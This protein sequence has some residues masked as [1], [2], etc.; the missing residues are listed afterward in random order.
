VVSDR[1]VEWQ[2]RNGGDG[3][4]DGD[5]GDG[6]GGAACV[7]HCAASRWCIAHMLIFLRCSRCVKNQA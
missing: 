1:V 7:H 4:N 6:G 3:G 5:G 2:G